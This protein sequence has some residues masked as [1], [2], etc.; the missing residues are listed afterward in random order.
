MMTEPTPA[1]RHDDRPATPSALQRVLHLYWRFARPM[2]LGVRAALIHPEHGV[3]L[4]RHTYVKGWHMPGGG[5]EAGE[6]VLEALHREVREEGNIVLDEVPQLHGLFFNARAS[7][8]DHVALYVSRR[9]TQTSPRLPDRE[10]AES[11]FFP[12]DVLPP[13]TT[14]A[15]RRR[16][17]EIQ[18]GASPADRW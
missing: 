2:T 10:I 13:E 14:P 8:R 3:F 15:T 9:F 12:L 6:T 16:L 1:K 11:G 18:A 5:V 7:R 4:I 17:A